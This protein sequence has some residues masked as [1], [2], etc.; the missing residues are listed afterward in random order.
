MTVEVFTEARGTWSVDWAIVRAIVRSNAN[1]YATIRNGHRRRE[2]QSTWWNPFSYALP[3]LVSYE[4]DWSAQRRDREEITERGMR[5]A[6]LIPEREGCEALKE[7]LRVRISETDAY[8]AAFRQ[9]LTRASSETMRNIDHAVT[10]YQAGADAARFVRD[11]SVDVVLVGAT[12]A[13]GGTALALAGAGASLRG[14]YS[15]QDHQNVGRAVFES[16]STFVMTAIPIG[17]AARGAGAVVSTTQRVT[18]QA[19]VVMIGAQFE[20]AKALIAGETVE[21]G[22][23][24][25][26]TNAAASV[27]LGQLLNMDQVKAL[28][29]RLPL[30]ADIVIR[31]GSTASVPGAQLAEGLVGSLADSQ[32]AGRLADAASAALAPVQ[33]QRG[34]GRTAPAPAVCS[35]SEMACAQLEALDIAVQRIDSR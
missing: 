1:Q 15:Y 18:E 13:S 7:W 24:R 25:A 8:R 31:S 29:G 11:R 16:T 2:D 32:I 26:G 35:M 34:G 5:E 27:A 6:A 17:M 22:L 30:P 14:A 21:Q 4:V 3:D 28:I 33:R 20:F 12:V 19:V 23:A 10:T 9:N